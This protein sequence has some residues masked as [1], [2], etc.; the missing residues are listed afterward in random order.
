MMVEI[1][2]NTTLKDASLHH[3]KTRTDTEGCLPSGKKLIGETGVS[4][5]GPHSGRGI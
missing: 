5:P 3:K 2:K 4:V 1:N